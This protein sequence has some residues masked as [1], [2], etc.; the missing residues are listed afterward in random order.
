[1]VP[2]CHN[3]DTIVVLLSVKCGGRLEGDIGTE[4]LH[5]GVN[6]VFWQCGTFFPLANSLVELYQ[7]GLVCLPSKSKIKVNKERGM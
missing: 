3:P 1:M 5:R 7:L 6:V 4:I 2:T